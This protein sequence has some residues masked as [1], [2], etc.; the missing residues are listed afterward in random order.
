MRTAIFPARFEQ[1]DVIREFAAKAARDA[2]MEEGDIYAV[3][4]S[5]DEACSNIIE[6]AYAGT[7]GGEIEC[8]CSHDLHALKIILRDH[9]R[10]FDPSVVPDPDL[11]AKLED[12][13]VGG[14]GIFLM[15]QLMDEVHFEPLGESGNLLTL[16]KRRNVAEPFPELRQSPWHRIL[17]LGGEVMR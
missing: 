5:I 16:V 9:G 14:L 7:D 10:P 3:E 11:G 4:L 17:V 12:R 15:K 2:G 6:H 13:Q 1:L 8:T